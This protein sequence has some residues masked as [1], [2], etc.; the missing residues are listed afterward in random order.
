MKIGIMQPY[1][2]PYI[3]YWQ[4]INAVDV[5]VVYDNIQFTKKGW[6]KR[7]R[8][9]MNGKEMIISLPIKNDSDYLN[10]NERFLPETFSK[11][12]TKILNQIKAAY[13]KAPEFD[14]VFPILERSMNCGKDNL[15]DFIYVT[16]DEIVNYLGINTKIVISSSINMDHSLKNKER[17]ISTC[18]T[19][20]GDQYLNPIGGMELY[21]KAYFSSHGIDLKF[22]KT[23]DIEYNQ[24]E[25][26]FIS[27]LSI[28]DVLMFNSQDKIKELLNCYSL[29]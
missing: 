10:I 12:R 1:F 22:I 8:I 20:G 26:S 6:I 23:D 13:N 19:L 27:N 21:D 4:L 9:M 11:D 7:N 29:Q 25:Y 15:F 18:K 2:F 3:G 17:V 16:I 28:I 24:F 14:S 5:F